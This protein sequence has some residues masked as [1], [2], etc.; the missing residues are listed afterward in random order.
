MAMQS[1]AW[2]TNFVF[3]ELMSFFKRL[4]PSGIS[5]IN[6]HL[7]ILVG[8]ES[9]VTLKTIE[10]AQNLGLNMIILPNHTNHAM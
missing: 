4:I 3:K 7:F 6:K 5:L 9:H 8:H 10:Q 2:M 1:K